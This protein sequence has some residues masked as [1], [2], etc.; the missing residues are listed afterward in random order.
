MDNSNAD[1]RNRL[2]GVNVPTIERYVSVGVGLAAAG[3]GV[4]ASILGSRRAGLIVGSAV[5][6]AGLALIAR[7]V[8]GVCPLNRMMARRRAERG[9]GD[10]TMFAGANQGEGDRRAARSYNEHVRDFIDDDRVEPAA[11][12]AASAIDGPEGPSLRAAEEAGKAPINR[13][14]L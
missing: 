3:A 13:G 11:R 4:A 14:P 8:T 6:A 5:A 12:S 7:G 10:A 2:E 1:L 9:Q